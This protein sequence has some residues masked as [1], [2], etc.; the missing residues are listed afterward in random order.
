MPGRLTATLAYILRQDSCHKN[1][2][3]FPPGPNYEQHSKT[4]AF[5]QC[6]YS[7]PLR[8]YNTIR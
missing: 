4:G 1:A 6:Q 3:E 5:R 8:F 7:T 2:P